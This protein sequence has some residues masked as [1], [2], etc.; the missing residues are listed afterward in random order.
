MAVKDF[1]TNI[2]EKLENQLHVYSSFVGFSKAFDT[3]D[4]CTL[5]Y[6]LRDVGFRGFI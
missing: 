6:R 4:H 1:I 5:L 2:N 3:T